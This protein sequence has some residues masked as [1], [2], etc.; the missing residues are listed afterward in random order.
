MLLL[1]LYCQNQSIVKDTLNEREKA[2]TDQCS[3]PIN[4]AGGDGATVAE[5]A[6]LGEGYRRVTARS[7]GTRLLVVKAEVAYQIFVRKYS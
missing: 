2:V 7:L 1:F 4:E 5:R 6:S 3:R